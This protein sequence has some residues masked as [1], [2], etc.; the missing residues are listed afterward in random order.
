MVSAP[1]IVLFILGCPKMRVFQVTSVV[2]VTPTQ[3][4]VVCSIE[5]ALLK[6][7]FALLYKY[8]GIAST[9]AA[10]YTKRRSSQAFLSH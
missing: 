1:S 2:S 8:R 4:V 5:T 7:T 3:L 6:Y 10:F 9:T